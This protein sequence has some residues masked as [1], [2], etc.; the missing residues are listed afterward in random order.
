MTRKDR[1]IM[2]WTWKRFGYISRSRNA[3]RKE[4]WQLGGVGLLPTNLTS[5]V[6]LF[7]LFDGSMAISDDLTVHSRLLSKEDYAY[8]VVAWLDTHSCVDSG[9]ANG[10]G[11]HHDW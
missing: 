1:P 11:C 8:V 2:A 6:V 7:L 4:R 5:A 9:A 3:F 10:Q